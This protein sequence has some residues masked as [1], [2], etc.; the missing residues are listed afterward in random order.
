MNLFSRSGLA[1][2]GIMVANGVGV[3]DSNYRG[4]IC[5]LLHNTTEAL[6][7]IKAGERIAQIAINRV[8]SFDMEVVTELDETL[9]GDNG[10]GSSGNH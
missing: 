8:I 1:F 3:I 2:K 4:E 10:F 9:R 7:K 6:F 5:V